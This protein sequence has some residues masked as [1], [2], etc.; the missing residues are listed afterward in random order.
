M[1]LEFISPGEMPQR[2]LE[3]LFFFGLNLP[4]F[5]GS[6]FHLAVLALVLLGFSGYYYVPFSL[7]FCTR[8]PSNSSFFC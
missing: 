5:L 1:E 2:G 8:Q 3:A 6:M 4:V 7:L